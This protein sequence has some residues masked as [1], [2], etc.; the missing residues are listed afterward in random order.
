M[1][2]GPRVSIIIPAWNGAAFLP[3][4]LDS[5]LSWLAPE[6]EL[7]VVDD[8]STDGTAAIADSRAIDARVRVIRN[9]ANTG[10]AHAANLGLAAA[11]GDVRILLNQDTVSARDWLT[12]LL[13]AMTSDARIGIA[14]C[15]LLYPDGRV[16]HAGGR[17][18][19]RGEG[20]HFG[21][22]PSLDS[23][24][25]ADVDFVTGAC[26]AVTRA[27]LTTIGPLDE[28]FGRAYFED[29]DWC[30]RARTAGYRVVYSGRAELIHAESS[31]SAGADFE[32][33]VRF[34]GNRLRFVVKHFAPDA[35][36]YGFPEAE[37][38]WLRGLGPGG[39]RLIVAMQ[40]VY[41]RHLLNLG[42]LVHARQACQPAPARA[43]E[44]DTIARALVSLRALAPF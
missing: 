23:S 2:S 11:G 26:L 33:M 1:L 6:H 7:L 3:A 40:R 34:H 32:S 9:A 17:V 43:D 38:R 10:F 12:P 21:H 25:L 28:G 14:G 27:C 8:G 30:Y 31:A 29:V 20:A 4:C 15:R 42:R 37:R 18:N 39:E 19:E 13:A 22:D 41:F 35:L 16:Q 5:L 24:G 44:V 36:A